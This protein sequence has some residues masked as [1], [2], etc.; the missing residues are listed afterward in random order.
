LKSPSNGSALFNGTSDRIVVGNYLDQGTGNATYAYWMYSTEKDTG[1]AVIAKSNGGSFSTSYGYLLGVQAINSIYYFT[2]STNGSNYTGYIP[3]P[4]LNN[5]YHIAF[6]VDKS[7]SAV[8]IY[9]NGNAQSVTSSGT[10]SNI[11]NVTNS[12]NF[13]IGDETDG[14]SEHNFGGNLSNVAIWSRA[15]S[16]EEVRSVMMKSYDDLSASETK[17]LVSWY[18]LDDISGTTVPDSHGNFNGTAY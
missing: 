14:A 17:G 5:W 4:G 8:G 18:A 10:L 15:L 7:K 2:A 12:L 1:Q 13:V 11:A 9:I 6:V 3:H 16:A